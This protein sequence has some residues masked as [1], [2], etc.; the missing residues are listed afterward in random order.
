VLARAFEL[1][2]GSNDKWRDRT[3]N[4]DLSPSREVANPSRYAHSKASDVVAAHLDL[5]G[6][7]PGA[8]V[9]PKLRGTGHNLGGTTKR[10]PGGVEGG[11][12]AIACRLHLVAAVA[13]E[14]GSNQGVVVVGKS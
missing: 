8:Q 9:Q 5:A 10:P 4:A 14:R 6:V 11:E 13:A 1:E 2:V 7:D 3:R 12:E